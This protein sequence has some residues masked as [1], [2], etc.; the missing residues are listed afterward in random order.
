METT[1]GTFRVL[2]P[3]VNSKASGRM[4]DSLVSRT[5]YSPRELKAAIRC[6]YFLPDSHPIVIDIKRV[7]PWLGREWQDIFMI[8]SYGYSFQNIAHYWRQ[9]RPD[10][11]RSN[12]T[13]VG[14]M[15]VHKLIRRIVWLMSLAPVEAKPLLTPPFREP[16]VGRDKVK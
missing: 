1:D 10:K 5:N 8:Y 12:R 15:L 2:S 13:D 3:R 6:W 16:A 4:D 11:R 14:Y 7:Y 9:L